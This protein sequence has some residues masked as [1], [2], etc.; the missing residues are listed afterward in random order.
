MAR[1]S[2]NQDQIAAGSKLGAGS[3]LATSD[4]TF[5]LGNAPIFASDGSLTDSGLVPG[6]NGTVVYVNGVFVGNLVNTV[7][8][9]GAAPDTSSFAINGSPI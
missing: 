6:G 8:F 9:F 1:G 3:K 5:S 7:E 2:I 4:G